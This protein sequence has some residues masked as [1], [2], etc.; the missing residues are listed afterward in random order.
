MKADEA[1][2]RAVDQLQRLI[3]C[4]VPRIVKAHGGLCADGTRL[5]KRKVRASAY[6]GERDPK[7]YL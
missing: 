1:V 4:S 5:L 7:M 2:F 3:D 6:E